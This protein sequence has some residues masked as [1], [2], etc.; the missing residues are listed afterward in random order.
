MN[1]T[2][3]IAITL[4]FSAVL[5][6]A[7][8]HDK[9][10]DSYNYMRGIEAFHNEQYADAISYFEQEVAEHPNNGYAHYYIAFINYNYDLAGAAMEA[11]DNCLKTLPK[12][13][14]E[15]RAAANNTKGNI[16]LSLGDTVK[17][18]E[19]KTEAIKQLPNETKILEFPR[20]DI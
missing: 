18:L 16:Y 20:P 8:D 12:K 4:L 5:A 6:H 3:L 14:K 19:F 9:M 17:A 11:I 2:I 1:R 15:W 13:N 7:E 10:M